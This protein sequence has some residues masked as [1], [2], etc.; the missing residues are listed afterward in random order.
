M[1]NEATLVDVLEASRVAELS[2]AQG[3]A[4]RLFDEVEARGLIR[5]GIT[6][7]ELNK[8]ILRPGARTLWNLDVLA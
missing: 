1:A 5:A 2:I 8:E 6:E 4:E 3:K 7:S